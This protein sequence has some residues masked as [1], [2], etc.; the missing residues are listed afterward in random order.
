MQTTTRKAIPGSHGGYPTG[1]RHLL[2][3]AIVAGVLSVGC[4]TVRPEEDFAKPFD[5]AK[6]AQLG[7]EARQAARD[8]TFWA[9]RDLHFGAYPF[10]ALD[11]EVVVY[12]E[13]LSWKVPWVARAVE[14]H[15]ATPRRSSQSA[16]N[17]AAFEAKMLRARYQPAPFQPS[18]RAQI[19]SVLR[20]MDELSSYYQLTKP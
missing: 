4:R 20:L 15:A 5:P 9:W 11:W 3:V 13:R 6:V 17:V 8:A 2:G 1:L 16:Y 19:E 14:R 7:H 12:L 10:T 18:T